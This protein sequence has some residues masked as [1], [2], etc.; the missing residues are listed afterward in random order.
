[1]LKAIKAAAQF[2]RKFSHATIDTVRLF[3]KC[4]PTLIKGLAANFT[5][6]FARGCP[7]PLPVEAVTLPLMAMPAPCDHQSTTRKGSNAYYERLS[8][9]RCGVLLTM[10]PKVN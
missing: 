8:C 6:E 9:A 7:R 4:V 2:F 3:G 1:M 10:V 5:R